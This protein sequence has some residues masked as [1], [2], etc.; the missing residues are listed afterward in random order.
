MSVW[1]QLGLSE[2]TVGYF[3]GVVVRMREEE[4]SMYGDDHTNHPSFL[5][6]MFQA[7]DTLTTYLVMCLKKTVK[8][9]DNWM[10][11]CLLPYIG[12]IWGNEKYENHYSYF[13]I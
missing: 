3:R 10:S 4:E 11:G 5:P 6:L 9:V 2:N 1:R 8:D 13:I 7:E 12:N